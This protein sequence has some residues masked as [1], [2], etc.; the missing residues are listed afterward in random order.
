MQDAPRP[1]PFF[2]F[3]SGC[4][5]LVTSAQARETRRKF[6]PGPDFRRRGASSGAG[7]GFPFRFQL[8]PFFFRCRQQGAGA[9]GVGGG[10][11][12]GLAVAGIEVGVRQGRV[13]A[14]DVV[15][16]AGEQALQFLQAVGVLEGQFAGLPC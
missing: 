9:V 16:E 1:V 10:A 5:S 3:S 13:V 2:E 8:Q 4:E 11:V 15:G 6:V 14:G 12:E 7:Q